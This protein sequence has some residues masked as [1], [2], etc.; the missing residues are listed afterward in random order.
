MK[1]KYKYEDGKFLENDRKDNEIL[2]LRAENSNLK[3]QIEKNED[4][5]KLIKENGT[6][7]NFKVLNILWIILLIVGPT[8]LCILLL[9]FC[10]LFLVN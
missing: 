10:G 6:P 1:T 2:I 9:N 7:F 3:A 4:E 8:T 5:I